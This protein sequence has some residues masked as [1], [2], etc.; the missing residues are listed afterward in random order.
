LFT[1]HRQKIITFHHVIPRRYFDESLCLGVSCTDDVFDYQLKLI[2]EKLKFTT[3]VGERNSC[4]ITFDDGYNNNYSIALPILEK[5]KIKAIFFIT[6]NLIVNRQT[7]WIDLLL[8]WCSYVPEGSYKIDGI[9]IAISDKNRSLVY[10]YVINQIKKNYSIKDNIISLIDE[11]FPFKML[12]INPVLDDLRFK[13]LSISQLDYIKNEG[14][15]VASHTIDH[16]ILSLLDKHKLNEEIDNSVD[17]YSKFCNCNYFAYPFGGTSEVSKDVL[18]A[19]DNS[20]YDFCF[21]NYWNY[22]TDFNKKRVE[23]FSLPNTKKKYVIDAYLSGFY[24]FFKKSI[25]HV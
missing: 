15:L 23:R 4:M 19:Y 1:R 16:D 17:L 24:S 13:A 8:K 10:D 5:Y 20:I 6:F 14:H 7:L 11:A 25:K 2:S 12:R 22:Y 3:D 18:S 9:E 21:V